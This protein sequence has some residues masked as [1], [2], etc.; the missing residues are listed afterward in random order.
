MLLYFISCSNT[1]RKGI[2]FKQIRAV[3]SK[4]IVSDLK[5]KMPGDFIVIDSIIVVCDPLSSTNIFKLYDIK[6]GRFLFE[7]GIKGHGPAEIIT[8]CNL[9]FRNNRLQVYDVNLRKYF[10]YC[11]NWNDS[12]IIPEVSNW[13]KFGISI[14]NVVKL[15]NNNYVTNSD[16]SG[17]LFSNIDLLKEKKSY[18]GDNPIPSIKNISNST[19]VFQG[20]LRTDI[21]GTRIV[22]ATFQTPYLCLYE[23]ENNKLIKQFDVLLTTPSYKISN[24]ELVWNKD[25]VLGFMDMAVIGHSVY[26]LHS[27]LKKS[28][29]RGRSV[30]VLPKMLYEFDFNGTPLCKYNLDKPFL[31]IT[32]DKKGRIFGIT[33][34]DN[35]YDIVE[36]FKSK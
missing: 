23:L 17:Y 12:T 30:N 27:N 28:E 1:D 25:N 2:N 24:N 14:Y 26:L 20:I 21:T 36:I 13:E 34:N 3:T 6:T 18:F 15:S 16:S 5:I 33:L 35:K 7:G 32:G 22:Y 9:D 29:G 31:R 11:I 10:K 8:P 4:C 19:D